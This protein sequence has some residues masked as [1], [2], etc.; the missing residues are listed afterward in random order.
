MPAEDAEA[1]TQGY[2]RVNMP[3]VLRRH[4]LMRLR[5][6]GSGEMALRS[7]AFSLQGCG[8]ARVSGAVPKR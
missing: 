1:L 4:D 8:G 3:F 5:F 7:A 2:Q 6:Y